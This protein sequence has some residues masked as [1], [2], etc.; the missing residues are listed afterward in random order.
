MSAENEQNVKKMY[1]TLH[2]VDKPNVVG[3]SWYRFL[4]LWL[5]AAEC[6]NV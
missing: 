1:I 3:K 2:N 5:N 4:S 6:R